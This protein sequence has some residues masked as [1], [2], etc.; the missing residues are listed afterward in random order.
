MRIFFALFFLTASLFAITGCSGFFYYPDHRVYL[1]PENYHIQYTDY[2]IESANHVRL[3][4]RWFPSALKETRG[5]IL[6]FHGNAENLTSHYASLI[7]LINEGYDLITFDYR[8]YGDSQGKPDPEGIRN[9]ALNTIQFVFKK[10]D[11]SKKTKKIFLYGQSIGG[12][13]LLDALTQLKTDPGISGII[14]ESTFDSYKNLAI[15]KLSRQWFT[16][17]FIPLAAMIVSDATS[18]HGKL[19]KL[20][21]GVPKLVFHGDVDMVIPE[22]YG[23]HLFNELGNPKKYILV[24]GGA[25]LNMYNLKNGI[26]KK[27]LL[28]F[29]ANA[30]SENLSSFDYDQQ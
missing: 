18:P 16:W 6:Q 22:K 14:L 12:A 19:G 24:K 1:P 3:H 9:D 7:W 4:V 29:L 30:K 25:H 21:A 28:D 27:D 2:T 13:I 20:P 26:Y 5:H 17:I 8:G 15:G 10:T 23:L 11:D